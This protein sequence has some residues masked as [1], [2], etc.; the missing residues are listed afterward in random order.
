MKKI[1]SLVI[2]FLFTHS[3]SPVYRTT[4]QFES[5]TTEKGRVCAN[6]CL[7]KLR[8]CQN[9]CNTQRSECRR[10]QD[11]KAEN[12]YLRYVNDRQREGQEVERERRHFENYNVCDNKCETQCESV[13]RICHVNCG[14]KVTANRYCS[15]FCE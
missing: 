5:P 15:A 1:L 12:A 14:G 9:S 6:N 8:T 7:D 11:L 2:L 10:I 13:Q 4:Y 3:C